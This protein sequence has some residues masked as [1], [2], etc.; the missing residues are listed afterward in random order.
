M[1]S[2]AHFTFLRRLGPPD[3]SL[4]PSN[5]NG[6]STSNSTSYS[7]STN[8]GLRFYLD[9]RDADP[10]NNNDRDPFPPTILD[11]DRIANQ[12]NQL[13]TEPGDE[14]DEREDITVRLQHREG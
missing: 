10:T 13:D 7:N 8:A 12:V 2:D 1:S 5:P 3:H 4:H 9:S 11:R 6:Q 14:Q